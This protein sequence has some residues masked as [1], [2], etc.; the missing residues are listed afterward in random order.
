[1]EERIRF[2]NHKGQQVLLVDFS[3]CTAQ[4][5]LELLPD[6]QEIVTEQPQG[7]LLTLGDYTGTEVRREVADAMKKV[8]LF[9][10]RHVKRSAF[11]GTEHVPRMFLE[12]FQTFAQREIQF[13][14]T[15]A[16][17]LDWLV[18]EQAAA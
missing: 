11:V 12:A 18:E 17:A 8:L 1:M 2:I 7:S 9:D 14:K 16:E 13:C 5:V 10:R 6:V 3:H 4:E 15:R